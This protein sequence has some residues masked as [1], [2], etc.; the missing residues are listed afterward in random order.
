[1]LKAI[2]QYLEKLDAGYKL[3]VFNHKNYKHANDTIEYFNKHARALIGTLPP[4]LSAFL[5]I[6]C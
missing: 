2:E 1:M 3:E 6:K 5:F 4:G